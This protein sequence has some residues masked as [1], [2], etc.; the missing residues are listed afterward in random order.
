MAIYVAFCDYEPGPFRS[1]LQGGDAV[2]EKGSESG[3]DGSELGAVGGT[4][5]YVSKSGRRYSR[6]VNMCNIFELVEPIVSVYVS[7]KLV[8]HATQT[9]RFLRKRAP[10]PKPRSCHRMANP[11][12]RAV[13]LSIRRRMKS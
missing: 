5:E 6:K 13:N 3:V 8:S 9:G 4:A 7:V 2:M 1:L 12:K 10:P 11:K